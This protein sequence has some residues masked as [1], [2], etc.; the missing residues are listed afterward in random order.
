MIENMEILNSLASDLHELSTSS[1]R[2]ESALDKGD[3]KLILEF[4]D[5]YQEFLSELQ[6][7]IKYLKE[8]CEPDES[9]ICVER[10]LELS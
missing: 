8:N 2:F 5:Y 4:L 10:I 1:Y 6:E 3:T 9:N 7:G